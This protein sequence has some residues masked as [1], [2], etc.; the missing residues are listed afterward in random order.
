VGKKLQH[1]GM[2]IPDFGDLAGLIQSI[3]TNPQQ[4]LEVG[5]SCLFGGIYVSKFLKFWKSEFDFGVR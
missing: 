4:R 3:R 1:L 5:G 2:Q